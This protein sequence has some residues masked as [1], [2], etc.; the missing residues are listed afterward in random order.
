MCAWN[1]HYCWPGSCS[2]EL[3]RNCVCSHGFSAIH[4]SAE[5]SCQRNYLQEPTVISYEGPYR[6]SLSAQ[7]IAVAFGFGRI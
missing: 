6:K 7:H 4:T 5:T 1:N 2:D 3:V